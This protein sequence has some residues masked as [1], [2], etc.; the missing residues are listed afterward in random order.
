MAD[1][2]PAY[3]RPQFESVCLTGV[4]GDEL[5]KELKK[6]LKKYR[7]QHLPKVQKA[8]GKWVAAAR[9]YEQAAGRTPR[10]FG[11]FGTQPCMTES[12]LGGANEA[13]EVDNLSVAASDPPLL[14]VYLPTDLAQ[15]CVADRSFQELPTKYCPGVVIAMNCRPYD[16]F[17]SA[18]SISGKYHSRWCT[19][20]EREQ[21]QYFLAIVQ[22]DRFRF[23]GDEVWTRDTTRGRFDIVAHGQM[24]WPPPMPPTDWPSA[25]GW[26]D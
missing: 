18:T 21:M 17:I 26:E 8:Q 19:N 23:A 1:N 16:P 15:P 11:A 3:E 10:D 14:Y 7:K 6:A 2:Y 20:V 25:S 4:T 22:T 13:I 5:R 24:S 9:A 12:P